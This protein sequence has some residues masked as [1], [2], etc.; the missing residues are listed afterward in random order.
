MFGKILYLQG[1]QGIRK[2]NNYEQKISIL[3]LSSFTWMG[4]ILATFIGTVQS[5]QSPMW[6]QRLCQMDVWHAECGRKRLTNRKW[7][8]VHR[9]PLFKFPFCIMAILTYPVKIHSPSGTF[10]SYFSLKASFLVLKAMDI[11]WLPRGSTIL[12]SDEASARPTRRCLTCLWQ[13]QREKMLLG[14]AEG[15]LYVFICFG[16]GIMSTGWWLMMVNDG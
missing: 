3:A 1:L 12:A 15:M 13:P 2:M 6:A 5:W 9:I 14:D 4:P 11:L 8:W 10:L 7:F 16:Y